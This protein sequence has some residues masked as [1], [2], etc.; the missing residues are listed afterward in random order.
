MPAPLSS[1]VSIQ[2]IEETSETVDVGKVDLE[3]LL[4]ALTK[5]KLMHDIESNP[6]PSLS[7]DLPT[8]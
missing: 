2:E 7:T 5:L 4:H 6:G 3:K 1:F 8:R